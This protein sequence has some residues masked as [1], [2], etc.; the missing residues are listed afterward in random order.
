MDKKL[1]DYI[2]EL[3]KRDKKTLSQKALKVS[4]ECGEL[5]KAILPFDSAYATRHRFID[6]TK[7]LEEVSDTILTSISIAYDLGFSH[8]DIEEMLDKK[9]K[10]WQELQS[11]EDNI[12]YPLP[13]EIHITVERYEREG[14]DFIESFMK[15]CTE[16][17][18]KPIVL[19]LENKDGHQIKDVMTSSKFYGDNRT[20]YEESQR[21]VNVL[22]HKG[23]KVVREKI[24]SAP[25]HPG[26]PKKEIDVVPAGC[27]FESHIAVE[28]DGLEETKN[29]LINV[30]KILDAHLSKNIFKKVSEGKY[31]IMLTIR[32][33]KTYRKKFDDRIQEAMDFLKNE[34]WITPKKEVE[35]CIYDTKI[36]H[37]YLWLK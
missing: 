6:K 25:W 36:S 2:Q 28:I 12:T 1:L 18:V 35:F 16:M 22:I 23:F 9:S 11:G 37:D 32:D 4:E 19:S 34:G 15:S 27:Y 13:F 26:A 21:I 29:K 7:I 31:V 5:A 14:C 30:A 3:S 20:V 8:E 10:K 24:E 17:N 33:Y